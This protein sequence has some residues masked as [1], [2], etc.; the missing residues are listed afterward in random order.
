[1]A[2]I[3]VC[4]KLGVRIGTRTPVL[5]KAVNCDFSVFFID[6]VIDVVLGLQDS[7]VIPGRVWSLP[8]RQV[9]LRAHCSGE[10]GGEGG[11]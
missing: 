7:T 4:L 2:N 5:A 10:G 3:T 1:M 8:V 11:G 6:I 9:S